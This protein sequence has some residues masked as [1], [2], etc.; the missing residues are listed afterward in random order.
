LHEYAEGLRQ[1]ADFA[2]AHPNLVDEDCFGLNVN[3]FAR[4]RAEMAVMVRELG[5]AE[6]YESGAFYYLRRRFGPHNL[7]LCINRE[8]VCERIQTGTR[9]VTRPDPKVVADIPMVEVEEPV[10]EWVCPDSILRPE[11]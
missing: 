5:S 9:V 3:V 8:Q 11:G 1:L 6:K 2:E 4:D 7:D 10:Y